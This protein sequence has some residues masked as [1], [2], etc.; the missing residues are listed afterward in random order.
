MAEGGKQGLAPPGISVFDRVKTK[1]NMDASEVKR[2]IAGGENWNLYAE[3]F[4]AIVH[5]PAHRP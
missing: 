4:T 1:V 5:R 2:L 3:Q